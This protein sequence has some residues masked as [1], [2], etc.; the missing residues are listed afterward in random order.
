MNGVEL[1]CYHH[2]DD[3]R[4]LNLGCVDIDSNDAEIVERLLAAYPSRFNKIGR[5]GCS[6][7]FKT[8]GLEDKAM[9]NFIV[10]SGG[11][12]EVFYSNKYVVIP[13][14]LHSCE[15]LMD[16]HYYWREEG[17][18][19]LD[20]D[21]RGGLSFI[22][23]EEICKI[24]TLINSPSLK[25]ANKNLPLSLQYDANG[26]SDGRNKAFGIVIGSYVKKNSSKF[27]MSELVQTMLVFDAA[28]SPNNSFFD[29]NY[30]K[31]HVEIKPNRSA[32]INCQSYAASMMASIEKRDTINY[33]EAQAIPIAVDSKD[34]SFHKIIEIKDLSV[35]E[36]NIFLPEFI[37]PIYRK[38]C[39]DMAEAFGTSLHTVFFT[40]LG[41]LGGTLQS[42]F[43]I[44]PIRNN[45]FFQRTNLSTI[46]LGYSGSKKSDII[47]HVMWRVT[48]LNETLKT[49]NPKEILDNQRALEKRMESLHKARDAAY[50]K[51]VKDEADNIS[52]EIYK[53]QDDLNDSLK[54]IKPTVW[55][56]HSGT[57]Q[58]M[59][60]DHSKN[61]KIGLFFTADEFNI[62]LSIMQKKGNEEFRNYM[63]ECQ[64]GD[65]RFESSTLSRLTDTIDPC[66]ASFLSTYQPDSFETKIND[67]YNGRKLENDGMWQRFSF[68][69]MD[70]PNMNAS[71]EFNP[72]NYKK[73]Y[74][75]F[76]HAFNMEPR[77]VNV[78]PGDVPYYRE[79]LKS[80]ELKADEYYSKPVSGFIS[81]NQ[82]RLCKYSIMAD[83]M[84][85]EGRCLGISSD[86]IDYADKW[87]NFQIK[88]IVRMFKM[89]ERREDIKEQLRLI[90]MINGGFLCDGDS[91]A[92][93]HQV[94]K[95]TFRTID[96][97]LKHL[98]VLEKHNYIMLIPLNTRSYVIKI[99]PEIRTYVNKA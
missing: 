42:K 75:L 58:K 21:D 11:A 8:D 46:L 90:D 48:Q 57:V 63:M 54:K 29:Y 89:G 50:A 95:G 40:L 27:S 67:L 17:W 1:Y 59:I 55:L 3:L 91:A 96:H 98:K 94:C 41:A 62:Y 4:C 7:F 85:T 78:L 99:N 33:I 31:R 52:I 39:I 35:D 77:E 25:S 30:N 22:S 49:C 28:N 32:F 93:W 9:L 72:M 64:N 26:M 97:L 12:I 82:G 56:Y 73:E 38:F 74:A 65:G 86:G 92:K 84:L 53:L 13:P 66:Y 34:I 61:S 10:P 20:A 76:D 2:G 16:H 79:V 87:I 81:K 69:S 37:P 6:F 5:K 51:G 19:L 36:S 80:I 18:T 68:I 60:N 24:G 14:S 45:I 44:R 71:G 70:R 47:K 43:I 83:F 88:D 15:G 23:Y